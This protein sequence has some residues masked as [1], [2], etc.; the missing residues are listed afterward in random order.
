MYLI[1]ENHNNKKSLVHCTL[2]VYHNLYCSVAIYAFFDAL[3]A[4]LLQYVLLNSNSCCFVT[5]LLQFTLFCRDDMI[6]A[7]YA[8]SQALLGWFPGTFNFY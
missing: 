2:L 5:I 7:K 8:L 1:P 6:G 4:V 3:Y